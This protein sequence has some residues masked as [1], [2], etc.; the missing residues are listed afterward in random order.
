MNVHVEILLV[1]FYGSFYFPKKLH[2]LDSKPSFF[3]TFL[4]LK[5]LD[6]L[7]VNFYVNILNVDIHLMA[8][9]L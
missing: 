9:V 5:Y 8:F 3:F 6:S 2:K 7:M 1:L 4:F